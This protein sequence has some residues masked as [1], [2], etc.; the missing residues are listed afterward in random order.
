MVSA[1]NDDAV[2]GLTAD[3]LKTRHHRGDFAPIRLAR[4]RLA[5]MLMQV[6]MED[7]FASKTPMI[8]GMHRARDG[9]AVDASTDVG[10]LDIVFVGNGVIAR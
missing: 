3:R 7:S 2:C 10:I 6:N 4:S 1:K 8:N 5:A 9:F